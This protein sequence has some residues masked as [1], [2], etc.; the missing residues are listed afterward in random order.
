MAET[1][2]C[3]NCGK[4]M[5]KTATGTVLT[6]YPA[7]YPMMWWCACGHQE[8]AGVERG[9]TADERRREEW[10]SANNPSAHE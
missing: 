3:P 8:S 9:T 4:Q 7:Q 10:E 6:T 5:I 2:E 1:K